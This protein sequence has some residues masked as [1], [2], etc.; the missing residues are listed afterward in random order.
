MSR[1]FASGGQSI[2][3]SASA[4]VLPVNIQG[5]FPFGL[6]GLISLLSKGLSRVFSST[7]IRKHQFFGSQPS[8]WFSYHIHTWLLEKPQLWLY[9]PL[10]AK[11]FL[12][13]NT[14]SRFA[15]AFLPEA[16]ILI[17]CLQSS[18]AVILEPQKTK[19]VTVSIFFPFY[20]PWSNGTRCHDLSFFNVES[21]ALI[22][23]HLSYTDFRIVVW[24]YRI[25]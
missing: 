5:W 24:F 11:W 2:G 12:L 4:S 14:L 9:Q 8:L 23:C 18:S 1:F 21:R 15:I 19:S 17:S 3:A 13:F 7:T 6:T 20:L 16:S 22:F 10:S 25:I